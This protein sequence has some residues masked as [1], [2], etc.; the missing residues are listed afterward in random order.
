[1]IRI[2]ALWAAAELC[3]R[4]LHRYPLGMSTLQEMEAAA[5]SLPSEQKQELLLFLAA[6]LRAEG[7]LPEARQFSTEQ[8]AAWISQDEADMRRFR[9]GL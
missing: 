9:G 8:L 7:S 2:R 1:M 3:H 4:I 6:P 5:E